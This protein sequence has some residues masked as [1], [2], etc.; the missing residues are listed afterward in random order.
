MRIRN[1]ILSLLETQ[2][3]PGK[4][5]DRLREKLLKEEGERRKGAQGLIVRPLASS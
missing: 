5:D 1:A 3:M 2:I 4:N